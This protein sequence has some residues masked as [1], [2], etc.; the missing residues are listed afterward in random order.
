MKLSVNAGAKPPLGDVASKTCLCFPRIFA[1]Q[2]SV[3]AGLSS[4]GLAAAQAGA[5]EPAA[6]TAAAPAA[7]LFTKPRRGVDA[8][9]SSI[10]NLLRK[11]VK[12]LLRCRARFF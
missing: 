1:T 6:K 7:I 2:A 11:V 9:R 8:D 4:F 12:N 5:N 3:K 10:A